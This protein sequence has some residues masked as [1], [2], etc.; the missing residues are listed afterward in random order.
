MSYIT[1]QDLEDEVGLDK[2]I[3]LTDDES[4]GVVGQKRADRAIG[5]AV[6]TFESYA[7]TRYTL[8]VPVTEKVKAAC[9]DLAIFHLYKA[10]ASSEDEGRYKVRKEAHDATLKWLCDVQSGK[11]GLD[12][13]AV[14]ETLA[15]PASPDEVLRGSD[16]SAVVFS[17]EKLSGY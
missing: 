17:D 9:V 8:P 12:V 3:Q 2:L 7:R 5:Y 15:N 11:A 1:A 4:A 14:E 13:P 16:R 6:G 10:R